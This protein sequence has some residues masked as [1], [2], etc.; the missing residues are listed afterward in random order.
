VA[1]WRSHPLHPLLVVAGLPT[2][3]IATGTGRYGWDGKERGK[4]WGYGGDMGEERGV[5][6]WVV[7]DE[8][9]MI[10]SDFSSNTH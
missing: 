5:E 7:L 8:I 2:S 4:E 10:F 1:E 6:E 3:A 9:T